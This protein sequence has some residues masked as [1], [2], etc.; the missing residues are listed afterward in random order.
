VNAPFISISDGTLSVTKNSSNKNNKR[1]NCQRRRETR[2][3]AMG[4]N[5]TKVHYMYV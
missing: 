2:V 4:V 1:K 3:M 5:I